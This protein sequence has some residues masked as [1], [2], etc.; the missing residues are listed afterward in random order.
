MDDLTKMAGTKIAEAIEAT[1]DTIEEIKSRAQAAN[2]SLMESLEESI[3][4]TAIFEIPRPALTIQQAAEI[5]GKSIRTVERSLLGRWGNKLPSGWTAKKVKASKGEEWR[6]IPPPGFRVRSQGQGIS[7]SLEKAFEFGGDGESQDE[8]DSTALAKRRF[9]AEDQSLDHPSIIIDRSEEVERLLRD[10]LQTNKQLAEERRHRL[11][12]MRNMNEM[13]NS[14][15]LL[16]VNVNEKAKMA[17]ELDA[18][19]KELEELK[20][21][22]EEA[23][24]TPWWKKF[25]GL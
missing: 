5:L 12:D 7:P 15:K 23:I 25:L 9:R 8:F 11:E 20:A 16:E 1:V 24:N 19:K 2:D 14:I 4:E 13:R 17:T 6:I 3:Q 10:L 18:T 21:K 22:Y